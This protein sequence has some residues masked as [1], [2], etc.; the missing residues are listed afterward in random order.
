VFGF[1]ELSVERLLVF[2]ESDFLQEMTPKKINKRKTGRV[3]LKV[4]DFINGF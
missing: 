4:W 2:S 3:F 1:E